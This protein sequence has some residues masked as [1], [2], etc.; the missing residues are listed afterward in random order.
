MFSVFGMISSA[1]LALFA[2]QL[3]SK[4]YA[5]EE[6][7]HG[8]MQTFRANHKGS[9]RV[10]PREVSA[11]ERETLTMSDQRKKIN[12]ESDMGQELFSNSIAF[13][14]RRSRHSLPRIIKSA[15]SVTSTSGRYYTPVSGR[16]PI[17]YAKR[18]V[19]VTYYPP[20]PFTTPT[21]GIAGK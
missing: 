3:C 8:N 12:L 6:M 4:V 5:V 13:Q 20:L 2:I 21:D 11:L 7:P 18:E 16:G 1:F 14:K 15:S 9:D 19:P 17:P 10:L